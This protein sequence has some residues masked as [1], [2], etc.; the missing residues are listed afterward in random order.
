M[1][2]YELPR[3]AV[4]LDYNNNCYFLLNIGDTTLEISLEKYTPFKFLYFKQ[5]LKNV[6]IWKVVLKYHML[7]DLNIPIKNIICYIIN[8][9]LTLKEIF[10][11]ISTEYEENL[12]DKIGFK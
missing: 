10:E 2:T 6:A 1:K 9:D 8:N 3:N 11:Y 5:Y 12:Y 4:L 7:N